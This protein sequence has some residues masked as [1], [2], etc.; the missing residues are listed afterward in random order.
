MRDLR[1]AHEGKRRAVTRPVENPLREGLRLE[2]MPEPFAFVLFGGTGDLAHRK[3]LPK[4]LLAALPAPALYAKAKFASLGQLAN[5][6]A[7]I[8]EQWP[9]K[10]G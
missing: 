4:N 8:A 6:K 2:R 7:K 1:L 5:A 10:M 3:V 9:S